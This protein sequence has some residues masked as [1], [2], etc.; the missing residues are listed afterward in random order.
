MTNPADA[1]AEVRPRDA[2]TVVLLRESGTSLHALMLQ[3]LGSMEFASGE[4]V[5][6]GGT[7]DS[8]DSSEASVR[9][10][11]AVPAGQMQRLRSTMHGETLPELS[12][13]GLCVGA[14]REV[15][16]ESGILLARHRDGAAANPGLL[17]SLQ[18]L[19]PELHNHPACFARLLS[20]HDLVLALDRL[21]Y[22]SNWTTP[23]H[24]PKRFDTRFFIAAL[25]EEQDVA[26]WLGESQA[27]HWLPLPANPASFDID[28]PIQSPPTWFTLQ[29]IARLYARLGSLGAL[30]AHARSLALPQVLP[31]R[32]KA[33]GRMFVVLPWDTCYAEA[34]GPAVPC[35]PDLARRYHGY[36]SRFEID[37]IAKR[38]RLIH[39]FVDTRN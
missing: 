12:A 34:A 14:C 23:V 5:F 31:K 30:L 21:V 29:E 11:S 19:R 9:Q 4:W 24:M 38:A 7:V 16:E 39:D 17:N 1:P 2:A 15:F 3:R 32:I 28:P 33:D 22:W 27:A 26:D 20:E 8:E 6:P 35:P 13:L 37:P 25:P 10:S 18:M 36:P